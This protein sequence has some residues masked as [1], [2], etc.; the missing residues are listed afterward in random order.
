MKKF[1]LYA[2][3]NVVNIVMIKGI[4][5][6]LKKSISR[7]NPL[8]YAKM[9]GVQIGERTKLIDNPNW[10][11]EPYLISIGDD[12][13]ISGGVTFTTHDMSVRVFNNL[14]PGLNVRKYGRIRIGNNCFIGMKSMIL[15]NV[16]IGDNCV[17]AAGAVVT[18]NIPDNEVWGRLSENSNNL[19]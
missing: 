9:Q 16:T 13:L 18:R 4:I 15:P 1:S 3:E 19:T 11:S 17:V 10:G 8:R 2:E 5:N 14:Q 7:M 12:C 6:R